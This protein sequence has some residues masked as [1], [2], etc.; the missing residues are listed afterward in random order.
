MT[1]FAVNSRELTRLIEARERDPGS[2]SFGDPR[3]GGDN[4]YDK[5]GKHYG[6]ANQPARP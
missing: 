4:L 2:A 3:P 5:A 6:R 1:P